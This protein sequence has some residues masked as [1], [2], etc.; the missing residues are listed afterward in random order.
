M[1]VR[2]MTFL[3]LALVLTPFI[4]SRIV[5]QSGQVDTVRLGCPITVHNLS[6]G[7]SFNI[8]IYLWNDEEIGGVSLGFHWNSNL[9]EI[10]SWDVDSSVI[11]VSVRDK[12]KSLSYPDSNQ[13][14]AGWVDM[15]GE[16]SIP[17][18][19][20]NQALLL[21]KL[22]MRLLSGDCTDFGVD[23]DSVEKV[24]PDGRWI[25]STRLGYREYPEYSDCGTVD[26]IMTVPD[27]DG[28][29]V[30]DTCDTC[31]DSDADGSGNPG[32]PH[33]TCP[34]DN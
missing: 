28:D 20:G 10:L 29:G 2:I 4:G 5:A 14:L 3:W 1:T 6:P 33:N 27:F 8:P 34:V 18:T 11:P 21:G 17:P 26:V 32:F 7:D 23:V 31:T 12:K 25:L 13:F 24:Y 15:S 9:V 16:G 19:S 22:H 30:S